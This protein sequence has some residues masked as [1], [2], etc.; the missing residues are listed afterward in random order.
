VTAAILYKLI[1]GFVHKTL[2][3]EENLRSSRDLLNALIEGTTDAV[4]VKD[5][6]GRYLI[7]NT[8]SEKITGRIAA[9][10]IGND[11][12]ML[13]SA[14]ESGAIMAGDRQVMESAKVMTY[15][16]LLTSADGIHRTFLSTKGPIFSERGEVTGLFGIS[17]D[18][19]ERKELEEQLRQSQKM[20]AI[21]QLAGG[22]AHDFNNILTA[23]YG[24]CNILQ[25]KVG[26]DA[27]F[28]PDIDQILYAADRATNLTRSLL[29]FS[30]K[31]LISPRTLNV[32]DI[33]L[34]ICKLLN[35]IIGE[36]IR[37]ITQFKSNQMHVLV[38]SGQIEQMLINLATNARDAMPDGGT[39]TIET[40]IRSLEEGF[41]HDHGF[42]PPGNYGVIA[43]ADS[44]R[45][46]SR[47]TA[48]KIFEPFFTTKEI[49]KGTGLGLAIVYGI[50]KQHN[51]FITVTS[52]L[53]QGTVF[54]VFLPLAE[55]CP[56]NAMDVASSPPPSGCETVLVAEDDVF[57]RELADSVLRKSGYRVISAHD[58]LEAVARFKENQEIVDIIIMDMIM[59]KKSGREALGEIRKI[60]PGAK[61]IFISGYNP[62]ALQK[63]GFI[64]NSEELL[65]KPFQSLELLRRIRNVLDS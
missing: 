14:E 38:D 23:I 9:E 52:T 51:G 37:L 50:V 46:M 2:E 26:K 60:R 17:R 4:F 12:T 21:G 7:F 33:V 53:E 36:D 58:G 63:R 59:P 44:G 34:N 48:Q 61:C 43:V 32:N 27:P 8:A 47:E 3:V 42:V 65:I 24:F 62:E 10:V 41:P 45:G 55:A 19:S 57:I 40:E 11:D 20:E 15:E 22:I 56:E 6:Q 39:L 18:I 35:R 29:T 25:M 54:T 16:D 31:Q 30:R 64:D 13:F 49:G 1:L 5:R 28:R